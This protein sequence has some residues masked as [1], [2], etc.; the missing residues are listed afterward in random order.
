MDK[1]NN[2]INNF[3]R[4]QYGE[5]DVSLLQKRNIG[6]LNNQRGGVYEDNY[7]LYKVIRIAANSNDRCED[8]AI[9]IQ[10]YAYVDDICHIDKK[11]LIKYNYQL[12]RRSSESPVW[13][14]SISDD[15]RK[16]KHVDLEFHKM[17]SSYNILVVSNKNAATKNNCKVPND[18]IGC[19]W[20]EYFPYY[21]NNYEML[22]EPTI[23]ESIMSLLESTS[24]DSDV[25]Y[26]L[27]LLRGIL[28]S[29]EYDTVNDV[30]SKA[31]SWANP[32]PFFKYRDDPAIPKW[33]KDYLDSPYVVSSVK[34]RDRLKVEISDG[35]ETLNINCSISELVN[36]KPKG[37]SFWDIIQFLIS[38]N[39]V[40]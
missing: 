33:L 31:G 26:A 2:K 23:R 3:I 39:G 30:F 15:F 10:Q 17:E 34:E 38:A 1:S 29:G 6:G 36:R 11:N 35:K 16:Q 28:K 7:L 40:N 24:S 12:K 27:T 32:N 20:S 8:Q 13:N 25:D 37:N 22:S 4:E 9:C 21:K 19:A 5:D 18:L 14:D